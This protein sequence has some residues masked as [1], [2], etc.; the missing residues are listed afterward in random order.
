MQFHPSI[1]KI[2]LD[3]C[4]LIPCRSLLMVPI[5]K[6]ENKTESSSTLE[7]LLKDLKQIV[8]KHK[9]LPLKLD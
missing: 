8:F 9:S 2:L 4:K 7:S 1:A 3:F 6:Y 5:F